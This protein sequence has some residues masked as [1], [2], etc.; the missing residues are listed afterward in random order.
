[1]DQSAPPKWTNLE[2]G[3]NS[4]VEALAARTTFPSFNARFRSSGPLTSTAAS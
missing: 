2:P 4:G 3:A 1:V